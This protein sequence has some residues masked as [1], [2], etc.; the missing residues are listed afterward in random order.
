MHTFFFFFFIKFFFPFWI[1]QFEEGNVSGEKRLRYSG[2]P[3]TP[4][5]LEWQNWPPPIKSHWL[6]TM[7][8]IVSIYFNAYM[9]IPTYNHINVHIHILLL[10]IVLATSSDIGGNGAG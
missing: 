8:Y 4:E 9:Y 3:T 5:L 10:I 1:L 7:E 6:D 2:V